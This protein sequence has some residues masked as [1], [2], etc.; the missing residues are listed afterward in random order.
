MWAAGSPRRL[1]E[2]T[3][4]DQGD[5]FAAPPGVGRPVSP[6]LRAVRVCPRSLWPLDPIAA[7]PKAESVV[8]D[9]FR[10]DVAARIAEEKAANLAA[11]VRPKPV[12]DGR[13]WLREALKRER[14]RG[15]G[16]KPRR[17]KKEVAGGNQ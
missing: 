3:G 4:V 15:K 17:A 5:D 12:D 10:A 7:A 11:M 2:M 6:D 9:A 8:S 16:E 14:E 13:G 1:A